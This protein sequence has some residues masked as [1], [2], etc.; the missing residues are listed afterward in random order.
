[1]AEQA[2][3]RVVLVACQVEEEVPKDHEVSAMTIAPVLAEG[4]V[5]HGMLFPV[6]QGLKG[7]CFL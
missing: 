6:Q 2:L 4:V 7:E 1:M 5:A 3:Q